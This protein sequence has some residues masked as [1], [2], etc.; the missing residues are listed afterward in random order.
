[1]EG[2]SKQARARAGGF[3]DTRKHIEMKRRQEK[4]LKLRR[5]GY[6]IREIHA[7]MPEYSS[8]KVIR[9]ELRRLLKNM[10]E[11]PAQELLALQYHRF[12][13]LIRSIWRE[14]VAGD[15]QTHDRLL[16][17]LVEQGKMMKMGAAGNGEDDGSDVAKWLNALVSDA[18]EA[19][20][21]DIE[22]EDD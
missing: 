2:K 7:R 13:V 19:E 5:A 12:E 18:G 21:E 1:M 15:L 16:K 11:L 17:L 4:L 10:V 14:A 20:A 8:E 6:T 3:G 9:Q 22:D